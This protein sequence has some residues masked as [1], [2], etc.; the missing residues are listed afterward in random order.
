MTSTHGY[1]RLYWVK[2]ASGDSVITLNGVVFVHGISTSR[3]ERKAWY[4]TI[5]NKLVELGMDDYIIKDGKAHLHIAE[6]R[7]LGDF[8]GDLEDLFRWKV[9]RDDAVDDVADTI[10]RAWGDLTDAVGPNKSGLVV[11]AHS[12]GQPISIMALKNI[13]K[14]SL[15]PFPVTTSLLTIGGPLRNNNP[16]FD[17]YLSVGMGKKENS[18]LLTPWVKALV[19]SKPVQI[20][21]WVDVYNVHDR[22]C[23][24]QFLG[25]KAYPG[26]SEVMFNYPGTPSPFD[27]VGEHSS[28]FK[29]RECYDI[30]K[31][32]FDKQRKDS[33]DTSVV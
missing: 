1:V 11:M 14:Y 23:H 22:I 4:P 7:S 32:M 30:L 18:G 24:D 28:Y 29:T 21:E 10:Y 25:S 20:K 2:E 6:W 8:A 9:R 31:K 26:S 33:V 17:K 27:P 16:V 15:E 5:L 12:M 3:A 19:P 13:T